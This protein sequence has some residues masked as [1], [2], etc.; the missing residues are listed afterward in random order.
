MTVFQNQVATNIHTVMGSELFSPH[1]G[2]VITNSLIQCS[3]K[4]AIRSSLV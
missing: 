4:I 2:R 1:N 3:S